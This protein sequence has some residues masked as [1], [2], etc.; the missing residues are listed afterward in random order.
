MAHGDMSYFARPSSAAVKI[1]APPSDEP[2][3][4]KP[5]PAKKG[6]SLSTC[7]LASPL[8]CPQMPRSGNVGIFSFM[9]QS[10]PVSDLSHLLTYRNIA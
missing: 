8:T 5:S 9:G 10:V 7:T 6:R 2:A 1:S 3:S 4:P